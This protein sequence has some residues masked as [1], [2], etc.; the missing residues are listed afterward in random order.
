M[1]KKHNIVNEREELYAVCNEWVERVGD[2][3][4]SGGDKPNAGDFSVFGAFQ[5]C[6]NLPVHEDVLSNTGLGP[7]YERMKTAVGDSSRAARA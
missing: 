3:P 2:R 4:F 7:W 5:V 6:E 1:K